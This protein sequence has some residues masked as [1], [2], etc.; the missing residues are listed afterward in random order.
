MERLKEVTIFHEYSLQ[1]LFCVFEE[2][3][4]HISELAD[5]A[6]QIADF[7]AY[8]IEGMRGSDFCEIIS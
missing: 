1:A 6:K 5:F 3:F 7:I 2:F 8:K 4:C